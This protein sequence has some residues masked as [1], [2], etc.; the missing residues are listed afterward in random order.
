MKAGY[1]LYPLPTML[2]LSINNHKTLEQ[3]ILTA[4]HL[5]N[6]PRRHVLAMAHTWVG[7][8]ASHWCEFGIRNAATSAQQTHILVA[9]WL[10]GI[11]AQP[12]WWVLQLVPHTMQLR[13]D[14]FFG[15]SLTQQSQQRYVFVTSNSNSTHPPSLRTALPTSVAAFLFS[16]SF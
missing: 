9:V 12:F 15:P 16:K 10:Q 6:Y 7:L 4:I 2:G 11:G 13:L 5:F 14:N 1:P 8:W 3:K